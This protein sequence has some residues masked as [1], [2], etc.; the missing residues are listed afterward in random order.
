MGTISL[1]AAIQAHEHSTRDLAAALDA[2]MASDEIATRLALTTCLD[3]FN[4]YTIHGPTPEARRRM[5]NAR[6]VCRAALGIED[7]A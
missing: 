4:Y 3:T 6:R 2:M 1:D 5:K 7:E